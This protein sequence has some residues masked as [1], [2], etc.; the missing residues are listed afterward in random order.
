[1]FEYCDLDWRR[2]LVRFSDC[3]R[4]AFVEAATE[5]IASSMVAAKQM[6]GVSNRS[7]I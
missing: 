3:L 5:L 2:I 7:A 1:M 4:Y 6:L